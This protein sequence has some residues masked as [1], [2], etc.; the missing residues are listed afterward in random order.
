M[1]AVGPDLQPTVI[2]KMLWEFISSSYQHVNIEKIDDFAISKN[3]ATLVPAV[4]DYRFAPLLL[5][6]NKSNF[7]G[8][9]ENT[10]RYLFST[11]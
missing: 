1:K 8:L 11:G 5:L 10:L 9:I 4:L 6:F 3:L 7:F 2:Q